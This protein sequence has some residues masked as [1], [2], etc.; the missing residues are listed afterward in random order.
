MFNLLKHHIKCVALILIL[1]IT[2]LRVGA[3]MRVG[4]IEGRV[5]GAEGEGLY[6][7]MVIV[8]G[9]TQGAATDVDGHFIIRNVAAGHSTLEVKLLGYTNRTLSV[10]VVAGHS[11]STGDIVMQP[12]DK[13][14]NEVQVVGKSAVRRQQEMAFAVSVVDMSMAYNS[15]ISMGNIVGKESSVRVR[16]DGGMGSNYSFSINGFSG[17]QVK[18]FL[19]G[20]P[21]DNFGSSF[22]L[23]TLPSN[24][25]ERIDVYKGVLPVELGSDALGGAINIVS[26]RNANYLDASYSFG[27]FNTHKINISGAYTSENG[28]SLRTTLYANYSDNDYKVNVQIV[29]LSTGAKG[30]YRKVRRFADAFR[31]LGTWAELGVVGKPWADRLLV[32][33]IA[34]ASENKIQTG[35]TMDAVY[36]GIVSVNHSIV[37]TLRYTKDDIFID[38][39]SLSLFGT[40]GAVGTEYTD[41]LARRYNWLGEWTETTT[42]GEFSLSDSKIGNREWQAVA[43]LSYIMTEHQSLTASNS[44]STNV[45]KSRNDAVPDE[46]TNDVEQNLT[47][48]V[49]ALG[50]KVNFDKWNLLAFLKNYHLA[51]STYKQFDIFTDNERWEKVSSTKN[52]VGYGAAL[53]FFPIVDVQ[54]KSSFEQACRMPE[55]NEMFGDGLIQKSN[56]DLKPETSRNFNIGAGYSR[57]FRNGQ[58]LSVD[59]NFIYR[60]SEDFIRKGVSVSSN[61]TTSYDNLGKVKTRGVEGGVKYE[62]QFFHVGGDVTFQDIVDDARTVKVTGSYVGS[63]ETENITYGQR[64]P[65]IPYLFANGEFGVRFSNVGLQHSVLTLDYN[66]SYVHEYFLSFPG[67]GSVSS[68]KIIPEQTNHSLAI[69]YTFSDGRYSIAGECN[70]LTDA[71]LYDNYKLQKPGRSFSVK[72]RYFINKK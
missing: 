63:G 5:V 70:N 55:V 51:N 43:T 64:L 41:T 50:Y 32:G 52:K 31:S 42:R 72:L 9:T 26:R 17:N 1:T 54:I 45:R 21:M 66:C 15:T 34:S 53:T 13:E 20:I 29:D 25:A 14:L 40:Y 57:V 71:E 3:Q 18:F 2:S 12:I 27:S 69:G 49:S 10:D 19:D 62:S 46:P 36:G 48:N 24:M 56:T 60:N 28:F 38:C 44:F 30:D 11:I 33:I 6:A 35:A 59:A 65:N 58:R 47:K 61:P 4:N 39:L 7:A 37:P 23:S 68:K 8:A 67:L 16:E 22:S